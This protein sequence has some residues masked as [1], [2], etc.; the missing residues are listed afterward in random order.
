[1]GFQESPCNT[2][3]GWGG[4]L[5]MCGNVWKMDSVELGLSPLRSDVRC[6]HEVSDIL[7]LINCPGGL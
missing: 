2:Q 6:Y 5:N 7:K 4:G 3:Y 1:M